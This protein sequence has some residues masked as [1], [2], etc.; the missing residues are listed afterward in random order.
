MATKNIP[1]DPIGYQRLLDDIKQATQELHE[2][3]RSRAEQLRS[4]HSED[5]LLDTCGYLTLERQ[6]Q[7]KLDDLIEKKKCAV[8]VESNHSADIVGFGSI[9]KVLFLD[10]SNS[11]MVFKVVS[12]SPRDGEV[13][14]QSPIGKALYGHRV[15]DIIE[16]SVGDCCFQAKVIG[17]D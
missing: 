9:V 13:S 8:I 11:S 17:V 1:M 5:A 6:A 16:Y 14:V 7:S 10:D 12:N 2:I 15:G 4:L 3:Q